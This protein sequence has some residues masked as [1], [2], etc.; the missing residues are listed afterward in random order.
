MLDSLRLVC[1][2]N[3]EDPFSHSEELLVVLLACAFYNLV[4]G[5]Q[6]LM[7]GGPLAVL[8]KLLL[9]MFENLIG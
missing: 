3:V 5:H 6:S 2:G 9:N 8:S 4:E 1:L 7:E